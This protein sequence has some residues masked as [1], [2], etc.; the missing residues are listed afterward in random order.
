VHSPAEPVAIS[1]P[2]T[3]DQILAQRDEDGYI[4][5]LVEIVLGE[6]A[7]G[8]YE[9]FLNSLSIALTGSPLLMDIN[10]ETVPNA[11]PSTSTGV[12]VK[13]TGDPSNLIERAT[14]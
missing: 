9:D 1:L 4:T 7:D 3:L 10:F 12:V 11:R 13:V 8:D 14:R 2:L 6:V 5:G